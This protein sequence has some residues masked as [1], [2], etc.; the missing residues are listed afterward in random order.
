MEF[1]KIKLH[2]SEK[3]RAAVT[4][5]TLDDDY[6]VPDYRQDIV[7]VIKE[8]G[9]LRFDEVKAM[10]GA[11]W[12]KGSLVF[13]VLYRSD[14]QEGKISCLRGE[15]P[16]QERLNMDGLSEYDAVHA[17]G[18]ME[19]LTIGVINSRKL[20]VRAVIV[21][22]ASS[23][24][25]VDEELTC[26][27][28]DGS[29]YEQNIVEKEALKLLVV[30]RDICRQKSEAVLP[31]SKPNI[32]EILW[33]S[34]QLRNVESRLV[35]GKI[36]LSGEI[37][38]SI[39]YNDEEE[40]EHLSWY[41][42]TV[43]LDAQAECGVM[44]LKLLVVRRDICRQKSEAVLPSSKPNIREILWQSM[45]LRNVESRLVEGKIRLSGEILVSILYND[46]EEGE[47]LSWY[48]TTVPL[49]AQAECGV[50]EDDCIWQVQM[51]PLTMELEVKPDYDGEERILVMELALDTHIRIWKEEKIRLLTDLYS[52]Q[53][54][55]KPVFR[56]CPLERLLV[57]NAAKC[58]MTE[59]MEL[60]EDK[61]KVL[62]ICSCEGKVLLERQE[63]KP[64]GVLAEGTVEVN[65]LYI[66]PDDHMPVGAV[67]EIYPFSQL[68]EIP[69]MSAQAKVE[70]DA[71][72]EQLS[73]VMLD[74]EH[75]EIRAAVR[76]DLIAFVQEVIQNI[77]EATE[78]E[79]DLEM[80]R[81]R[82]GLVGYIAK[83][84]DDLWT[85]AKENHTTIQNIMETNHR[86]SEVLLAGEKVLIVKQVG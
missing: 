75:V 1:Q 68:V 51:V 58:R 49:D 34:M 53:K 6:N 7:K 5:I 56:E 24:K 73:A 74:Q 25:E 26:E 17:T 23:E 4:Q 60:K 69:E 82:P 9:E 83:A 30:R 79:P 64:D 63:I 40:G 14:K 11:A 67:Q 46:E 66:T 71:S 85:I 36:R 41:E 80:L 28:S 15:I 29:S 44:A 18:D 61:E 47:H 19:D 38:V 43:P 72:L 31:S 13:K 55:V 42:T 22:T 48:E 33:Q 16:F 32:R 59:Q 3:N 77:E 65:I 52:L 50:M 81:N 20:N 57:K 10:E 2:R 76:L 54:E 8:R 86:K 35:E 78:S 27:L 84:G 21:L 70:L 45:Q 62:Q 12:I 37:L 39:L